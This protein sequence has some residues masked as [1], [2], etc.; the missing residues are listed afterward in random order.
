MRI[1]A[2]ARN[3]GALSPDADLESMADFFESTLAGIRMAAKA[4]KNRQTLRNIA[5][6]ATRAYPVLDRRISP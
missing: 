2:Q 6:I 4:G 5:A 3:Q 1:L